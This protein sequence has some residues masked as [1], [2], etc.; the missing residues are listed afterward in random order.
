MYRNTL[1]TSPLHCV[2][3]TAYPRMDVICTKKTNGDNPWVEMQNTDT[4]NCPVEYFYL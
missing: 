1:D 4:F 2:L 3:G